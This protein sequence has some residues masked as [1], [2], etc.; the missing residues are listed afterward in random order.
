MQDIVESREMIR[1]IKAIH[2][3]YISELASEYFVVI[4]VCRNEFMKFMSYIIEQLLIPC[5]VYLK[6]F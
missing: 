5:I 6:S 3:R 4:Y 2:F 1:V